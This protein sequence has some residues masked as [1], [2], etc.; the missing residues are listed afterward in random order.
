MTIQAKF[1]NG[2][3]RPLVA[4]EIKEGTIVDVHVPHHEKVKPSSIRDIGFAGMWANRD[5][6]ADGLSYVN[7][8]RENSRG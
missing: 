3:F 4:V 5:D 6:I 7:R 8:F 1:E 2:V